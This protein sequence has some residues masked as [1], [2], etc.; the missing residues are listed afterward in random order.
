MKGECDAFSVQ[1]KRK[2]RKEKRDCK[3]RRKVQRMY[4]AFKNLKVKRKQG[5]Q[6]N[7]KEETGT[8]DVFGV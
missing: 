6:L 7:Q 1:K 5:N 4:L 2:R 3:R 8:T